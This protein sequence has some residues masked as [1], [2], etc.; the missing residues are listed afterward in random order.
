MMMLLLMLM[1]MLMMLLMLV[2]RMVNTMMMMLLQINGSVLP[3][4]EIQNREEAHRFGSQGLPQYEQTLNVTSQ[5]PRQ[6]R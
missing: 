1:L 6:N 5:L 4:P 2:N 3:L